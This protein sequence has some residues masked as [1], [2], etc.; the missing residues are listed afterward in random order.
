MILDTAG[1][2]GTGKW[3]SQTALDIQVP[4]PTITA[5]VFERNLSALKNERIS[6][7]KFFSD[8]SPA[9]GE[10]SK[11]FIESVRRALYVSKICSYAQGFSLLAKASEQHDWDLN[12]GNIAMIFRGGCII[13]AQFLNKIKEAYDKKPDLTN[14]LLDDYFKDIIEGYKQD[15]RDVVVAA[16]S[17]GISIPAF[18][19]ALS[20]FDSYRSEQL[21]ANLLQA[22]R[23]YFGAHTYE[24]TDKEGVFHT[25][26]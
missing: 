11:E 18:T 16:V 14:L 25:Q 7:S 17:E 9:N 20:Y 5:A 1:Q 26:W 4:I 2:K 23:D 19:S 10:K 24:R 8:P 13:R 12:L 21:P 22:Q 15:W 3:T 6:A